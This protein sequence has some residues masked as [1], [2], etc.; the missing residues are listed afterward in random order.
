MR[1]VI[2]A[3]AAL[4]LAAAVSA[5]PASA[6][7][8]ESLVWKKCAPCH[9][10][11][12]GRLARV[13]EI[14][15]TPEEWTVIVDRMYRLH[16]MEL[17]AGE[18]DTLLKELSATQILSPEEMAEV[19]YLHLFHNS[20][21]QEAPLGEEEERFFAA[22]VRCHSAG[23]VLSY[24]MTPESWAKVRDFHLWVDPAIVFQM[25]EMHWIEEADAVLE[26]LAKIYPYGQDWKAPA[27]KLAGSW[28]VLG[29]EPG[30]GTYRGKAEVKDLGGGEAALSGT[31]H[32]ADGT[33]E[34][35]SGEATVYGGYA[36]RTRTKHNGF[37][38]LGAYSWAD[39]VISGEHHFPA[40]DFR[41]SQSTWYPADGKARVLRVTPG[42]LLLGEETSLTIEGIGLPEVSAA[43]LRFAGG[44]V[45]V[46]WARRTSPEVIE[47]R[48]VSR[49]ATVGEASLQV[50][51]LEGVPVQ[52][53]PRVD[54]IAVVP[55]IG[56][57]RLDGGPHYPAEGVQFEAVAW[58]NGADFWDPS[59]DVELGPVSATFRLAEEV[60]RPGDDDLH[61]V[62]QIDTAGKY[63]P[64]GDYAPIPAREYSGEGS[65][66]VKVLAEY[67][68]GERTYVAEGRLAVTVPDY[69]QRIR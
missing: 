67:R 58:S 7:S 65:G 21:H 26:Y 33:S 63:L 22:C 59:D 43:D 11:V 34:S 48:V 28:F 40:P 57:A 37:E 66:W 68:R 12:D 69:I 46:L 60:T 1:K 51:R 2:L 56:R 52:L 64:I 6:F 5:P 14:R 61:W 49:V 16:G 47:A 41:T 27:P 31:L 18:M 25:R 44:T 23:K 29:R 54:Y 62:G 24:R 9:A 13:Q 45:E 30:K 38:T 42:Y 35:F 36:L 55:A 32:F 10:P 53:A 39:G 50:K 20:Q 15:T 17:A 19:S 4:A 3:G 8:K